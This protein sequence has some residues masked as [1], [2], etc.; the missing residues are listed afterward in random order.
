MQTVRCRFVLQ[1][2]KLNHERKDRKILVESLPHVDDY[3]RIDYRNYL[4]VKVTFIYSPKRGYY[5]PILDL[6]LGED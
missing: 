2:G 1:N 5:C 6:Y 3:I 4:V